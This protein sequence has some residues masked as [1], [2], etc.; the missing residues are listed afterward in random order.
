[1]ITLTPGPRRLQIKVPPSKSHA[2][3]L[4]IANFLAGDRACLAPTDGDSADVQATKRCLA[5]LAE[6]TTSPVLDCGESG[7]TLRFLAPVAAALGKRPTYIRRGR[8]ADRPFKDYQDLKA[9]LHELPGNVSSQFV[10]GLLF[11]LPLLSGNSQI[12]FTSPLESRGYVD[13][14]LAVLR[15]AGI[16]VESREDGFDVPGGQHY[17]LQSSS[18]EGDWSGAA[19]WFAM[20]ALGS[21][22]EISGLN[23]DSAQPDRAIRELTAD[24]PTTIDVSQ[25]PDIFPVLTIVAAFRG[26]RTTFT[27]IA[28]LRLKEC[29]RV[30]A[31]RVTL[32]KIGVAV[33]VSVESFTVLR[34]VES[35]PG[36]NFSA[37]GDHRIAMSVAVAATRSTGPVTIDDENCVSKSYPGFFDLFDFSAARAEMSK[38]G[39]ALDKAIA[40]NLKNRFLRIGAEYGSS[41]ATAVSG[42]RRH[43]EN[44]GVGAKRGDDVVNVVVNVVVKLTQSE[45]RAFHELERDGCLSAAKLAEKLSVTPRQAQR[46]IAALKK[47]AGLRRRGSDKSGEWYFARSAVNKRKD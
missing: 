31:M 37:F 39:A 25:Y 24:F 14:T 28:R 5:A 36:G 32:E 4:L 7:S 43:T 13:L 21:E 29:D 45:K 22:V 6:P 11:A 38:E 2:H 27:G 10:T 35:F 8:L 16:V 26:Q 1:M 42:L 17:R 41:V 33:E 40:A 12:R 18:V 15:G 47:K 46:L 20:N 44:S 23:P 19:F 3:R 9:G 30:E 34:G